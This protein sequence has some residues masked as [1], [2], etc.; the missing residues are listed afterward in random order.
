MT[1]SDFGKPPGFGNAAK[2][3]QR[4]EGNTQE[5]NASI[6]THQRASEHFSR[7]SKHH[8]DASRYHYEG[9]HSKANQSA[10]MAIGEA[11]LG[12]QLQMEDAKRQA[13]ER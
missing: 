5:N 9:D 10:L 3:K 2:D 11:S 13:M 12:L 7:A 1:T 8:Q 4:K 6:E